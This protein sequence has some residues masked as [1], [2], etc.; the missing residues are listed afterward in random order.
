[1]S[2]KAPLGLIK[3]RSMVLSRPIQIIEAL[4]YRRFECMNHFSCRKTTEIGIKRLSLHS[5]SGVEDNAR[6]I[7]HAAAGG[8]SHKAAQMSGWTFGS[9]RRL[10]P[11]RP[12]F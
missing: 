10:P 8:L 9:Q 4:F 2:R 3:T 7:A 1:M 5:V 12:V 11:A 6:G